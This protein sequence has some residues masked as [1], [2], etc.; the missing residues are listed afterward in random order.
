[1]RG[2]NDVTL[3]LRFSCG[4]SA[5]GLTPAEIQSIA[6]P[7][8]YAGR[9][10]LFELA[11]RT[12]VSRTELAFSVEVSVLSAAPPAA[13]TLHA[14]PL[15]PVALTRCEYVQLYLDTLSSEANSPFKHLCQC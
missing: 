2:V 3:T 7:K 4:P 5:G 15:A 13:V 6:P 1:M 12:V 10:R 8:T 11:P 14:G 9:P